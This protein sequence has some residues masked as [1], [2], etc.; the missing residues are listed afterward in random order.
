VRFQ[1]LT[2]AGMKMTI[3]WDVVLCS[4]VEIDQCFRGA[5]YHHHQGDMYIKY[6]QTSSSISSEILSALWQ[7]SWKFLWM[8]GKDGLNRKLSSL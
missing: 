4:L 1:V 5:Y 7:C 6:T 2:V 8:V 3:F